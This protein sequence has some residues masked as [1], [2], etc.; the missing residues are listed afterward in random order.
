MVSLNF[1][2]RSERIALA[3]R[4]LQAA[5][6]RRPGS[7]VPVVESRMPPSPY[8]YGER[9]QDFDKMLEHS[10]LLANDLAA[11][12]NDWPPFIDTFCTVVMVPEAFGCEV[13]I[14]DREVFW[15]RHAIQDIARVWDLKPRKPTESPHIRRNAG[16]IDYA[17][18]K[19]GTDLP[20]WTLDIQSPFGVAAQIVEPQELLTACATSPK[21]VHHLCGM[22]TD[23]TIEM[24]EA[25]LAQM[26]HPGFP[27][28][29]F[30]TITDHIGI[31]VADD[32]ALIMLSPE[33]YREFALPYNSRL[34]EAFGGVHIHS[35]GNYGHNLDNLLKITNIRSIQCHAGPGEFPLPVDSTEDTPFN[36]ARSRVTYYVDDNDVSRGAEY[37]ARHQEFFL[38][39]VLPRVFAGDMT[40][41][42]LQSCG[43][44]EGAGPARLNEAMQWTRS[45]LG[46][47]NGSYRPNA[48]STYANTG[49][50]SAQGS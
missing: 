32:T 15:A 18:R 43:C 25:H 38:E 22:I 39:Y 2:P 6:A 16:W 20:I 13:V 29:N 28:R 35:C 4:R 46:R 30:P 36:R 27:G 14:L 24:M 34:G 40:G 17:Q 37:Q 12:D 19:L 49:P 7:E 8:G 9:F 41:C 44:E 47:F 10:I 48:R 50:A 21:E 26:D 11:I 42:I 45:Q 33:T 3:E 5:Y 1:N 23:Y 31:C